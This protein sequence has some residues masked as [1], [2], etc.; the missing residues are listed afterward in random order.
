MLDMCRS[1]ILLTKI[2][3]QMWRDHPFSQRFETTERA[4]GGGGGGGGGG[5]GGGGGTLL[6]QY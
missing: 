3:N 4:A 6:A 1:I 5:E 2:A